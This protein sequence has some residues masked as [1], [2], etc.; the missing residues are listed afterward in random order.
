MASLVSPTLA[1]LIGVQ[2]K[3]LLPVPVDHY[4]DCNDLFELMTGEKGVPQDK[5][6]RLYIMGLR[7]DRI[8]RC[9]T[10]IFN[11]VQFSM[12]KSF[13]TK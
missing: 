10:T 11:S 6:Q 1:L 7:E 3:N 8:T 12:K 9:I 2:E 13:V 5:T 4:T